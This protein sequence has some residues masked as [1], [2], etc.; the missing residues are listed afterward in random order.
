MELEIKTRN[1]KTAGV[2]RDKIFITWRD[3]TKHYMKIFK[4][5]GISKDILEQ[6]LEHKINKIKI[7]VTNEDKVYVYDVLD[8]YNSKVSYNYMGDIQKF[9]EVKSF[10]SNKKKDLSSWIK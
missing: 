1:G 9:I 6:L 7:V 4:G 3:S 10:N 8:F 5:Y 2:I